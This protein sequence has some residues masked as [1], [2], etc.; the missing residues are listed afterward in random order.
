MVYSCGALHA[1]SEFCIFTYALLESCPPFWIP[2]FLNSWFSSYWMITEEGMRL[3]DFNWFPFLSFSECEHLLCLLY[4]CYLK[5]CI[6][7]TLWP[8]N[9][10]QPLHLVSAKGK[11]I[12]C[13]A[14][15]KTGNVG[16]NLYWE[17]VCSPWGLQAWFWQCVIF[18]SYADFCL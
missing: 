6:F 2:T 9:A 10:S 3:Y 1:F 11:V 7:H 16:L 5:Q 17:M 8:L 15:G 14:G 18:I 12:C 4:F 13:N